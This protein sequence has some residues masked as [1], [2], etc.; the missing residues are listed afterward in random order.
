MTGGLEG[1]EAKP[2]A[3]TRV[4]RWKASWRGDV[5]RRPEAD[6]PAV[7]VRPTEA[8]TARGDGDVRGW[9]Q[10]AGGD[11]AIGMIRGDLV[12]SELSEVREQTSE[13]LVAGGPQMAPSLRAA[14]SVGDAITDNGKR[15]PTPSEESDGS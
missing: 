6:D 12:G 1:A 10:L 8:G 14:R 11:N 5:A 4:N 9:L 2:S 13:E 15:Q 7:R 3:G